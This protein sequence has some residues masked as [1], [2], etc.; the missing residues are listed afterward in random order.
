MKSP[1][2]Y[3]AIRFF[4][5]FCLIAPCFANFADARVGE[6]RESLERRLL[7]AGGIVY[8]DEV[9]RQNR[10]RGMPYLRYMEFLGNSA[11]V[12]IYFKTAD[13][14][15]PTSSELDERRMGAG[16][17]LHVVYVSGIS[18]LEIYKRSQALS[19]HERNHLLVQM[20]QGSFWRV[21]EQSEKGEMVSAFGVDMIRDDASVRSKKLG[22]DAI[23]FVESDIDESLAELSESDLQKKAPVSVQGF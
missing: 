20:S 10:Q 7:N 5:F 17:D 15:S 16:W 3:S 8:R 21:L 9:L 1:G 4:L 14:R 18:V 2:F 23:L 13:G 19:E 11:E 12:R 22:N 6:R